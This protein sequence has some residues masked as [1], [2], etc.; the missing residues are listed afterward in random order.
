MEMYSLVTTKCPITG[1]SYYIA[2]ARKKL[3]IEGRQCSFEGQI[4]RRVFHKGPLSK[5]WTQL[6]NSVTLFGSQAKYFTWA[7]FFMRCVKSCNIKSIEFLTTG[8]T[9]GPLCLATSCTCLALWPLTPESDDG[10]ARSMFHTMASLTSYLNFVLRL[11]DGGRFHCFQTSQ[12]RW[13]FHHSV[14]THP[15]R[16]GIT[17]STVETFEWR[18]LWL[19]VIYIWCQLLR[20]MTK[21]AL[22]LA[23]N[24]FL[25]TEANF[26]FRITLQWNNY[27]A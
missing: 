26:N 21:F 27:P 2:D 19:W 23:S 8:P 6:G 12:R 16:Y 9:T 17:V 25:F 15:W 18:L 5:E 7:D 20:C 4:T 10:T 24:E 22:N 3:T 11:R 1:A 14:R 13:S